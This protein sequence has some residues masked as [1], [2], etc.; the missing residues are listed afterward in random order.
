M[1]EKM[2]RTI[3]LLTFMAFLLLVFMTEIAISHN[4]ETESYVAAESVK[5]VC[6]QDKSQYKVVCKY[7][8]YGKRTLALVVQDRKR[9]NRRVKRMVLR[10]GSGSFTWIGKKYKYHNLVKAGV[11]ITDFR[12]R[13]VVAS[14]EDYF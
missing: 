5:L 3:I 4:D 9:L 10:G 6:T 14:D 12:N 11:T 1:E 2:R 8:V 7:R 13:E